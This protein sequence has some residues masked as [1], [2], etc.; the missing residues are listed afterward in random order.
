MTKR[1]GLF[2]ILLLL[3]LVVCV[4][5]F[6]DVPISL[7][8][9]SLEDLQPS[10]VKLH[11]LT[12]RLKRQ[13]FTQPLELQPLATPLKLQPLNAQ[14]ELKP[15]A[16]V[17]KLPTIYS[18]G[19]RSGNRK[20]EDAILKTPTSE[21][22][23]FS[24]RI[25]DTASKG[26]HDPKNR[27]Y[28]IQL[29]VKALRGKLSLA[30]ATENITGINTKC[31]DLKIE[32]V[33]NCSVTAVSP[34]C[35]QRHLPE[36]L[37]ARIEQ[38]VFRDELQISEKY[39]GVIK[40]MSGELSGAHD[41][42]FVSGLSSNHYKEAQA[43][44][45]HVHEKILP[46][47]KNLTFVVYNLGL[48]EWE[49]GQVKKYCRCTFLS[50]PFHLLPPHYKTLKCFSFK[51]TIIRAM[52][53]RADVVIWSDTSLR[54]QEP[55][56]LKLMVDGAI[57]RGIQQRYLTT[58]YPNPSHTLG[59]MFHHF[60]DSPCAH[61]AFNQ[62]VGGFGIYH[63]EPLIER[64]VLDPWLACALSAECM[65]PVDQRKVQSCPYPWGTK[66]IGLCHRADQSAMT[67]ILAK[68]FREKYRHFVV[69]FNRHQT[70]SGNDPV[71]YFDILDKVETVTNGTH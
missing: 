7:W 36:R 54:M 65:C 22:K 31:R 52:Y 66:K 47:F 20:L 34:S 11:P 46:V 33:D 15:P 12:Q 1:K 44:I 28:V 9:H 8:A 32:H 70:R 21:K 45:R 14:Q 35:P 42:I 23:D 4:K 30:H 69:D 59:Q 38:L 71:N 61:M 3:G 50:F 37:E 57:E 5:Y 41:V 40:A 67:L 48:T 60:G 29:L 64:A 16:Q 43:L 39:R 6:K 10:W 17:L 53:E 63:R 18:E 27:T 62:V 51:P 56:A 55:G 49:A 24:F 26:I 19:K 25:N 68:L 2:L 13:P 58:N